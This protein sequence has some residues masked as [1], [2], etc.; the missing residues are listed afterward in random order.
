MRGWAAAQGELEA[1]TA[2][3]EEGLAALRAAG[4]NV[5]RSCYLALLADVR[6]RA[7]RP[8]SGQTALAEAFAFADESGERWW[9]ASFAG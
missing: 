3:I 9:E 7:G 4:A 8:G 5:R 6:G 2:A 1:G